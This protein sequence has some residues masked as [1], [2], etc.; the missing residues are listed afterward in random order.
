[1]PSPF[2]P[3]NVAEPV[4][5]RSFS[6]S[7]AMRKAVMDSVRTA[8]SQRVEEN[9][10][11]RFEFADVDYRQPK[12]FTKDDEKQAILGRKR[13]YW[14]LQGRMRLTNKA[15][16][17]VVSE[18]KTPR[19]IAHVPYASQR[20]TFIHNGSEYVVSNQTRLKPGIYNRRKDTGEIESQF[21]VL[22]GSGR[23]FRINMDP[24]TGLFRMN[25]G[26]SNIKLYPL[27][28][29]LGVNDSQLRE[30]WGDDL[31]NINRQAD[32]KDD[33]RVSTR[34][35]L[36]KLGN[37]AEKQARTQD[38]AREAVL[39]AFARMK[40][41]PEVTRRTMGEPMEGV[42]PEAIVKASQRLLAINRGEAEEDDRDALTYQSFHAPESFFRERVDKDAGRLLKAA[43]NKAKYH[44]DVGKVPNNYFTKQ[45]EGVL[46]GSGLAAPLTEINPVEVLD[47]RHKITRLGEG[48]IG[49]VQ[50]VSK[51][52]RNIHPS[53]FGFIDPIRAP[54][55][56][57]DQTEVLTADGW[58]RWQAVTEDDLFA[59]LLNGDRLGYHKAERLV[60]KPYAGPMYL[61][62]SRFIEYCVTPNHRMYVRPQPGTLRG[63]E[64]YNPDYRIESPEEVAGSKRLFKTGGHAP[65]DGSSLWFDLPKVDGGNATKN[66]DEPLPIGAWCSFLG[67]YLS[68][69]SYA[70]KD[71]YYNAKISQLITANPD[72]FAEISE[73]LA[74]LPFSW[75]YND[76]GYS[77]GGKQLVAYLSQFGK[78]DDKWI[79]DEVF[80]AP[81]EARQAFVD[82]I[83]AGDGR[84][85][86]YGVRSCLCTTSKRLADG[87]HRLLFEMGVA[88][89]ITFEKDDRE[90]RYLGCY[91]IHIHAHQERLL[92]HRSPRHPEGQFQTVDYDGMVYCATVPG[93]LLYVRRNNSCGFWCGNSDKIGLDQRLAHGVQ[94]GSDG[95]L[96]QR[97]VSKDGPKMVSV[98][99]FSDAIVA[100]PGE[101]RR[102]LKQL[103]KEGGPSSSKHQ[104]GQRDRRSFMKVRAMHNGKIK[105]VPMD[106][107][108][109]ELPASEN[110]FTPG[111]NFVPFASGIKGQRLLM[112][113]RMQSQAL[114]LKHGEAP[115]VQTLDEESGK[116]FNRLF[117]KEMG[118]SFADQG[119][120][121][122]KVTP[123]EI[124]VQ[125]DDGQTRSYDLYDYLPFNQ[126]TTINNTPM[127]AKGD[128]IEPG[129]LLAKSNYT[130]DKGDLAIGRNMRA[131]FHMMEGMTHED[132]IVLSASAAKKFSSEQLYNTNVERGDRVDNINRNAYVSKYPG[133]F[134]KQQMET[135]NED[136]VVKP[137]TVV[138]PGD[139]LVLA[140]GKASKRVAGSVGQAQKSGFTDAAET[141]DHHAPGVVTDIKKTSKGWNVSVL[142]HTPLK[143]G[144]K[145]SGSYGNKGVVARVVPDEEMP[146][147][148]QGNPI[149]MALNPMGVISRTNPSQLIEM[150][151]GKVAA[152]TGKP[153]VLP[154][155]SDES[156]VEMAMAELQ[157]NGLT[158][159]E[160]LTDPKTGRKIPDVFTGVQHMFKLHHLA[161]S[162]L[163]GRSTGGYSMDDSPAKGGKEGAKRIDTLGT[164][165]LLSHGATEVIRDAKL[166][167]GQRNDDY[168]RLFRLGMRPPEPKV[169][170]SYKKFENQL[171]AAGVNLK[172]SGKTTQVLPMSDY[173]VDQMAGNREITVADTVDFDKM[174]PV[175]GGLFDVALTGGQDGTKWSYIKLEEPLPNPI[176]EDP[177][178]VLLGLNTKKF[179]SVLSGEEELAGKTGGT[180][181]HAALKALDLDREMEASK[182]YIRS[183]RRTERDKHVKRI[184]T[185]DML[186]KSGIK[187]E[188]L[189]MT[190]VPVL[191]PKFRPVTKMEGTQ[192][193]SDANYLYKDLL[194]A[195]EN[196]RQFRDQFGD[197]GDSRKDLYGAFKA[198]VGMGNPISVENQERNVRG[199]L[200]QVFGNSPKFGQFQR[201]VLSQN[202]DMVGRGVIVPDPDMDIDEVGIPAD[203]AWS[204]YKPY[205]IRRLV[206]KGMKATHAMKAWSERDERA[207]K[208]LMG[209]LAERPVIVNRAPSLHKF[210]LMAHYPKLV[211]GD[212]I[213]LPIAV[214]GG[215]G[216]DFDGDALNIH[217]IDSDKAVDEA[218]RKM[219]P[220]KNL[221]SP[222]NFGVHMTPTQGHVTGLFM[223]TRE[224]QGAP[225]RF[226]TEKEVIAAYK[227]GEIDADTPVVIDG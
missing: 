25:V 143:E 45:L 14:A 69:G 3:E 136:G 32:D 85:N 34:K 124:L 108:Q 145:L 126:K 163:G 61:G 82:A 43:F 131:A 219:L 121:I 81:L 134:D 138:R 33:N 86:R 59:C 205:V 175:K 151:L 78:C 109:Y 118:A 168:W 130:D 196:V 48:G 100:F 223:A 67:W 13:L 213:R 112:G 7:G 227:R 113:A 110:M 96:Y 51:D 127:V 185:L 184:G 198:A 190:K 11:Y 97:V 111:T 19:T 38:E 31:A 179:D 141:W 165:G 191:P 50:A 22:P 1:M 154:G 211:P 99:Q 41:D 183:G 106:Q 115:L 162:K 188:D 128:R 177:V 203:M 90:D 114:P 42:S 206:R 12:E 37:Y 101:T 200:K 104:A 167:R 186:K 24:A 164:F 94:L 170:A 98:S 169:S 75:S 74:Q 139:P 35:V 27:L 222:K 17:E 158:D 152:K 77:V 8:Y 207:T 84:R 226:K 65:I 147:D 156:L 189:V 21:N 199:I 102:A 119:G 125:Q 182:Q 95:Q 137:G 10:E 87:F 172:K 15:T 70:A 62:K 122:K 166:R 212:A 204:T 153:Y 68:E 181:I 16:G 216:A 105:Y 60:A 135:I 149:E 133:R 29:D 89:R 132:A 58:K 103:E 117:S 173:D 116:S 201:K 194:E 159:T 140:V 93:G 176:M 120:T 202:V 123:T 20:G 57:D 217:V 180:A 56:Y 208:E 66:L 64:P 88:S 142:S 157:K 215:Q 39:S 91:I 214:L 44:Q 46:L 23:G 2:D 225:K 55:C 79:P 150:A 195:N 71:G 72:G 221:F 80:S 36:D 49:S 160:V 224:G 192:L 148:G 6:D 193:V 171:L 5:Y 18:D 47:A 73:V 161:E 209:E 155:F 174:E 40:L 107:V 30:L 144:D 26:Q 4:T 52:A 129:Q 83:L 220:S 197:A 218:K 28:K 63:G 210:N 187:P 53:Q 9:D 92:V 54:E 76:R 146:Q 178:K